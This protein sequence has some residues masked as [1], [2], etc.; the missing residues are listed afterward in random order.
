VAL[1]RIDQPEVAG[2]QQKCLPGQQDGDITVQHQSE[3]KVFMNVWC[4]VEQI[5]HKYFK[6]SFRM[7]NDLVFSFH[8]VYYDSIRQQISHVFSLN[9]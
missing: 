2:L 1:E 9:L 6:I 8:H 5:H 7:G 3:L 4:A